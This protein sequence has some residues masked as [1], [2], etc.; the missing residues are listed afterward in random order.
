MLGNKASDT[1]ALHFRAYVGDA[2]KK[3]SVSEWYKRLQEGCENVE[4]DESSGRPK[5]NSGTV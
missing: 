3:W 1:R 5:W 4:G 2:L